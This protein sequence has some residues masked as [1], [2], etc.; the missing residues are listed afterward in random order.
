MWLLPI[1][2]FAYIYI[3]QGNAA[4]QLKCGRI[5]NNHFIAY[6]QLSRKFASEKILKID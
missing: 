6:C 5:Y 2:S 1:A 4:T 3:L